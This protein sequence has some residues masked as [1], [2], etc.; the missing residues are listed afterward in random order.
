MLFAALVAT[1]ATVGGTRSRKAKVGALA[2][3]LRALAPAEIE[4]AVS[5]LAGEPRQ[6]RLGTGWRTLAGL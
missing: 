6:G 3:L 4:A 5:W 2:G 1:S